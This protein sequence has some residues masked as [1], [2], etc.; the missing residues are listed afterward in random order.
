MF[1]SLKGPHTA[2]GIL[3][4]EAEH[5]DGGLEFLRPHGRLKGGAVLAIPFNQANAVRQGSRPSPIED[6]DIVP[7]LEQ[8][9]DDAG[10]YVSRSADNANSHEREMTRNNPEGKEMTIQKT[11]IERII[12]HQG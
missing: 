12:R 5:V 9:P 10:A 7:D 2:P 1:D 8:E 11:V 4:V 6:R 3:G